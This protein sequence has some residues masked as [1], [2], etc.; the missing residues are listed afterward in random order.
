MNLL[1]VA[2]PKDLR[3]ALGH[4][5]LD[6]FDP[7]QGADQSLE[8]RDHNFHTWSGL[9]LGRADGCEALYP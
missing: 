2:S 5:K 8:N 6:S 1:I 9:R 4:E 3:L 7:D